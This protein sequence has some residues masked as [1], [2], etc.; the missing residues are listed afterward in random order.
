MVHLH[1]VRRDPLHHQVLVT[2]MIPFYELEPGVFTNC[3]RLECFMVVDNEM[4]NTT[5]EIM[6]P[7]GVF[8]KLVDGEPNQWLRV[9][10]KLEKEVRQILNLTRVRVQ[11]GRQIERPIML[12]PIQ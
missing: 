12:P 8:Y 11:E 4:K 3:Q 1:L 5:G 9:D 2:P 6:F 10:P 7:K